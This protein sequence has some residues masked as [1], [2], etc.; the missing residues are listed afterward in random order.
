MI[1]DMSEELPPIDVAF[2]VFGRHLPA[3]HAYPLYAA[4]AR[5]APALHKAPWLGIELISGT[6]L[7]KGM[8]QLPSRGARLFMRLP[9][10]KY[11]QTLVLAG[12]HLE[13]AGHP[14][15]IGSPISAR[16]LMPAPSVYA[17]TV[18]IKKFTDAEPFLDAAC[19]QL[20][21][22]GIKANLEMPS[23]DQGRFRRRI[24]N[25]KGKSVVGFSIAAHN[26]SDVDSLSLQ[27]HGIGGRRIMGCGIFFPIR[28]DRQNEVNTDGIQ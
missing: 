8:I 18:T 25:I 6:P 24:V 26:L 1:R 19:R 3:D 14:L 5:C 12:Q 22:L 28:S 17:R 7:G 21:A 9:A 23:D 27:S 4:I 11:E 20:D 10:D 13:I 16:P 2:A 15:R